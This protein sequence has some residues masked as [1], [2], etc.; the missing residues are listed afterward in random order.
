MKITNMIFLRIFLDRIHI[1][2]ENTEDLAHQVEFL[3]SKYSSYEVI[4]DIESGINF[5]RKG[6]KKIIKMAIANELI[7]FLLIYLLYQ[8]LI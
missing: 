7:E 4:T 1:N 6:L 5:K 3:Q 8:L 2:E